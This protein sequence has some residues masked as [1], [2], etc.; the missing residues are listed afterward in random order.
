ME[1]DTV[2][3]ERQMKATE[4]DMSLPETR[5]VPDFDDSVLPNRQDSLLLLVH[6]NIDNRVL[7]V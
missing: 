3:Q 6:V 7:C 5:K 2:I 4:G 1:N